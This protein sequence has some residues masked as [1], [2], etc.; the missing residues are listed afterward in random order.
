MDSQETF[1]PQRP[2]DLDSARRTLRPNWEQT[3][4]PEV[5][6]DKLASVTIIEEYVHEKEEAERREKARKEALYQQALHAS[7]QAA[8][9][10]PDPPE[11]KGV[12][13]YARERFGKPLHNPEAAARRHSV[14]KRLG[15]AILFTKRP[16]KNS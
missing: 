1:P 2:V 14:K 6:E 7:T 16:P 11:R 15:A 13:I 10:K 5:T 4:P 8:Q 3:P 9:V 12:L